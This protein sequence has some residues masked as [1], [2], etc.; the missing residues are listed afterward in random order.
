MNK[1]LFPD[2]VNSPDTSKEKHEYL[3]EIERI[4]NELAGFQPIETPR[5]EAWKNPAETAS[6]ESDCE[7][8]SQAENYY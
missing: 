4:R 3:Q 1:V 2:D 7:E 5:A 8:L 6:V